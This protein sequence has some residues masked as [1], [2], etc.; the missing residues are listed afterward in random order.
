MAHVGVQVAPFAVVPV[1][2]PFP[3]VGFVIVHVSALHTA[4]AGHAPVIPHVLR[5]AAAASE[6]PVLHAG[7]HVAACAAEV[8]QVPA[9]MPV[10]ARA[11]AAQLHV[12][13]AHVDS[14]TAPS[15]HVIGV[16]VYPVAPVGVHELPPSAVVRV[17]QPVVATAFVGIAAVLV[18][19][20]SHLPA[21]TTPAPTVPVHLKVAD[22]V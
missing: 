5:L 16:Q 14:V 12:V 21:L 15:L 4:V 6:Y 7:W 20:F 3:L 13:L 17:V 18:Q 10:F 11:V 22:G 9:T 1:Q 2:P 19:S 8:E